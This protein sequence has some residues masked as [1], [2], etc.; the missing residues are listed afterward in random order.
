MILLAMTVRNGAEVVCV[1]PTESV[2]RRQTWPT[3][4]CS[5]VSFCRGATAQAIKSHPLNYIDNGVICIA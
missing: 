5:R 3:L 2:V 4:V 1:A